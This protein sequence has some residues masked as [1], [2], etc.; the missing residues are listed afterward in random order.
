M[1]PMCTPLNVRADVDA[2]PHAARGRRY[3]AFPHECVELL[4]H[5]T[6][7][8]VQQ[9]FPTGM[10]VRPSVLL[11]SDICREPE[12]QWMCDLRMA[13]TPRPST[14]TGALYPNVSRLFS[15]A[16][17]EIWSGAQ[18]ESR[19]LQLEAE[20]NALQSTPHASSAP[21]PIRLAVL[22]AA[23]AVFLFLGVGSVWCYVR[24][25]RNVSHAPKL[26]PLCL[27][28]TDIECSSLLWARLPQRMAAALAIHH[29]VIRRCILR[30]KAY[31]VKTVGDSFM[32][33]VAKTE[34]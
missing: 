6:T 8:S 24:R 16:V 28:F 1:W 14:A 19:L 11:K 20:L 33:A 25:V 26:S 21:R 31:E 13:V 22:C 10:P 4:R 30:H 15:T 9:R 32:I 34:V 17:N 29:A 2:Y 12:R 23:V 27:L 3:T 5:L 7:E 18:A